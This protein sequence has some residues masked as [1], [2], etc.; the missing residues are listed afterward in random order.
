MTAAALNVWLG[1]RQ[2]NVATDMRAAL[3][4]ALAVS[5]YGEV[6]DALEKLR[7]EAWWMAKQLSA[8]G[9]PGRAGDSVD[10]A[11]DAARTALARITG[12]Q[13]AGSDGPKL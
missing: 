2:G 8:K 12:D 4:A 9:L 7:T 11:L 6:V 5:G 3:T 10:Q 13:L 1:S